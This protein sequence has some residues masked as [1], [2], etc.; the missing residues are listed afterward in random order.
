MEILNFFF[1]FE[2]E[3]NGFIH[4]LSLQLSGKTKQK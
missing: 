1:P 2:H 3:N 4:D